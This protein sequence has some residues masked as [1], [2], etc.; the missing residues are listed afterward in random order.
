M[1]MKSTHGSVSRAGL[2]RL[3]TQVA[4]GIAL[5]FGTACS[6]SAEPRPGEPD[7]GAGPHGDVL[8]ACAVWA[9]VGFEDTV[10]R[11]EQRRERLNRAIASGKSAAA[12]DR[13]YD[14]FVALLVEVRTLA[15]GNSFG[16]D[17][18]FERQDLPRAIDEQ[19]T[20]A[21]SGP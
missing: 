10:T 4:I 20:A 21:G 9:T 3:A 6:T 14:T 19:C 18:L 8:R 17:T 1:I 11:P 15:T 12:G 13:Q 7:F 5:L 2:G 16:V